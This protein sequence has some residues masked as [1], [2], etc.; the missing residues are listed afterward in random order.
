MGALLV[1]VL[2][3]LAPAFLARRSSTPGLGVLVGARPSDEIT[4][5]LTNGL[6]RTIAVQSDSLEFRGARGWMFLGPQVSFSTGVVMET[7]RNLGP[8]E[9][10]SFRVRPGAERLP[11]RVSFRWSTLYSPR[12]WRVQRAV[13]LWIRWATGSPRSGQSGELK[14]PELPP[15]P[16]SDAETR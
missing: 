12:W 2:L 10:F 9:R 11:W 6:T 3:L 14:G 5:S 15:P 7:T 16:S 4:V 1:L 8:G 13:D